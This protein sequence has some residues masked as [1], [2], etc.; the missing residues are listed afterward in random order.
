MPSTAIKTQR[1]LLASAVRTATN[2]TPIQK[3]P[4]AQFLRVYLNV[5]AASGTG[6]LTLVIRGYDKTSGNAAK[7]TTGG[8][9][10]ITT[11]IFVFELASSGQVAGGDVKETVSRPLPC[12]WDVQ[13]AHG[14]AS[15]YTY[16]VSCEVLGP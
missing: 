2:A 12:Q 8:G 3:D 1:G 14:D 13:I 10:I 5:S 16:S 4:V 6:G 9:A 15:N 11:G 7:L